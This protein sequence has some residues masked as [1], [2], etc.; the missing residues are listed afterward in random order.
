MTD[1]MRALEITKAGGPEVLQ[2]TD[3]PHAAASHGQVVIKWR[4]PCE[5]PRSLQPL[6]S[7]AP[8]PHRQRSAGLEA[9]GR[10]SPVGERA[11][12][13]WP[14]ATKVCALLP[15]GGY[16]EICRNARRPLSAR[17]PKLWSI[18]RSRLP[19]PKNLLYGLVQRVHAAAV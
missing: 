5:P 2:P 4:M 6:A 18:E 11:L 3:R 1:T 12:A 16:A 7:Y 13:V 17:C 9:S 8:H 15:G 14:W 19:L 10:C